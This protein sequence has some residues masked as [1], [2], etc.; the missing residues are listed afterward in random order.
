MSSGGL[1]GKDGDS[2]SAAN[3]IMPAF[4]LPRVLRL[5]DGGL[6]S[7]P[8]DLVVIVLALSL[9]SGVKI[10]LPSVSSRLDR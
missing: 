10:E 7:L 8:M 6:A 9:D 3:A 4:G 2:K 1:L 5:G